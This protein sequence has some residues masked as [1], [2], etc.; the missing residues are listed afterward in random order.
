[1]VRRLVLSSRYL[2]MTAAREV[3]SIGQHQVRFAKKNYYV[4]EIATGQVSSDPPAA[5][6][7]FK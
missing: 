1:M 2:V 6:K 7:V 3:G 4:A 5:V